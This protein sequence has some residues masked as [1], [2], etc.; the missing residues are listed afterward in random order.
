[1]IEP[2]CSMDES[3]PPSPRKSTWGSLMGVLTTNALWG[4]V[5]TSGELPTI[6]ASEQCA[7]RGSSSTPP[8]RTAQIP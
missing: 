7:P 1:M 6:P 2:S 8:A 3:L 4:L 5:L